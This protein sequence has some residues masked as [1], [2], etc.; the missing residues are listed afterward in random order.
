[1]SAT[2]AVAPPSPF[3]GGE[4]V[5]R[6]RGRDVRPDLACWSGRPARHRLP[7]PHEAEA[8]VRM[9]IDIDRLGSQKAPGYNSRAQVEADVSRWKRVIGYAL[10]SQA[11]GGRATESAIAVQVLNRVRDLGRPEYVRLA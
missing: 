10:R 2:L 1:M 7:R 3:A 5:V 8:E 6:H 9:T 4:P 11:D